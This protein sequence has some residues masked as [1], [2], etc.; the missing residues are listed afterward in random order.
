MTDDYGIA[1]NPTIPQTNQSNNTTN[2]PIVSSVADDGNRCLGCRRN[3]DMAAV[4][5]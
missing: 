3:E 1:M 4:P 2:A 5:F